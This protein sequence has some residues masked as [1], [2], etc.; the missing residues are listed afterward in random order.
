MSSAGL[1]ATVQRLWR[2]ARRACTLPMLA[3]VLVLAL[4]LGPL[5]TAPAHAAATTD[6]PPQATPPTA[7]QQRDG[8]RNA[9]DRGLLW[10]LDKG[11]QTGWLYG[12][13]HV[14]RQAWAFPGPRISQA[15]READTVALE[16]DVSDPA[17]L[18]DLAQAMAAL[19]AR[20][21]AHPLPAALQARLA[22][23]ARADCIAAP[24]FDAQPPLLQAIALATLAGRRDGLDPAFGQEFALGGLA[25]AAAKTLV[26]LET[27][28]GQLAAL[29]PDNP[30]ETTT[31]VARL[32]DQLETGQARRVLGQAAAVWARGDLDALARYDQ[33]CECAGNAADEAQLRRLNDGRNP[34]LADAIEAL[35]GRGGRVFAAVGAL[36]MTGPMALPRLM[37]QRGWRVER[38]TWPA[39]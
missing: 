36:H 16:L 19:Q 31:M 33:W 39:P 30:A 6:C 34:A 21:A 5:T 7:Q 28:A 3:L 13:L 8:V 4:V 24:G 22:A 37:A 29:A 14:G 10:R 17:V 23:L 9:H 20:S 11:G 32:V 27:P 2:A 15:L 12:T 25:R 35:L 18:A 38:I 26:S 1:V